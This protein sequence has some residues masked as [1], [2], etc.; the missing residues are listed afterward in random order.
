MSPVALF[1]RLP[2]PLPALLA[3]GGA[4]AL[5]W[6]LPRLGLAPWLALALASAFGLGLSLP[7]G[8]WWRRALIAL[9][10]PVSLALSGLAVVPA[11]AWLLPLLLLLL[12]YPLSAWR[13]APLFPTPA[14]ALRELA[15]HAP[16]PAGALVLDAGC[17]LGDGLKAL[18]AA[19]PQAQLHGLEGSWPLRV[20]SALRCPWA[21][22]RQGDIWRADWRA[23]ALV[24]LFQRPE[25]MARAVAK[26]RL[27]LQP[28]AW[29]VSLEFEAPALLPQ[30]RLRCPD[31]RTVWLYRTPF[32]PRQDAALP[33]SQK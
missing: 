30:A 14:Q 15:A 6:A 23:Y 11:W 5:F 20:L 25:S 26:A 21:R 2:W 24:Y 13:D 3:W 27:E 12:L 9:G 7:A 33:S 22:I 19:Y 16:L 1:A 18:R 32:S 4:W 8:S 29:L 17:G 31:G 28:G 10:F